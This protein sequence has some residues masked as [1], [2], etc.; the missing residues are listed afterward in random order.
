M[1]K[2]LLSV[3]LCG[4]LALSL[5]ACGNKEYFAPQIAV[6]QVLDNIQKA[7]TSANGA[8]DLDA[9]QEETV[10]AET[11]EQEEQEGALWNSIMKLLKKPS[12]PAKNNDKKKDTSTSTE[13]SVETKPETS[14]STEEPAKEETVK[15]ETTTSTETSVV[16]STEEKKDETVSSA[17]NDEGK[18]ASE[19]GESTPESAND[20]KAEES[21]SDS[22]PKQDTDDKKTE[23]EIAKTPE[24]DNSKNDSEV[25]ETEEPQDNTPETYSSVTLLL[26][27]ECGAEIKVLSVIN[28]KTGEQVNL[29]TL[30]VDE[31]FIL[32]VEWPSKAKNFRIAAYGADGTI[33]MEKALDFTG[34]TTSAAV[35]LEGTGS[36]ENISH[37]VE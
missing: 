32:K 36:L 4:V 14:T 6:E 11:V 34:I 5:V 20:E 37:E 35:V 7:S 27:N 10:V 25:T 18:N 17:S 28:P 33:I 2:K 23:D 22:E 19:S 26:I 9:F 16:T 12:T 21:A 24:A 31:M 3:T 1:V 13:T 30:G 8:I 29:G 15:E